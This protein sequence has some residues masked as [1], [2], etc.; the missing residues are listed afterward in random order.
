MEC[1]LAPRIPNKSK[2]EA[3][4]AVVG[5]TSGKIYAIFE[6]KFFAD[7]FCADIV[8]NGEVREIIE[9]YK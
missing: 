8:S 3:K 2:F 5:V 6:C 1:L 9:E 7:R 4:W